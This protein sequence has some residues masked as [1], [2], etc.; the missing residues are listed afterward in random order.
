MDGRGATRMDLLRC[1]WEVTRPTRQMSRKR[2]QPL[3]AASCSESAPGTG[4]H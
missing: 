3:A 1:H 2:S 4:K